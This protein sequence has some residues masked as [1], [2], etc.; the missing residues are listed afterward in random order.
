MSLPLRRLSGPSMV[1]PV[2]EEKGRQGTRE[3][4][5]NSTF[6]CLLPL[7]LRA[8]PPLWALA[9]PRRHHLP[10]CVAVVLPPARR[11][12]LARYPSFRLPAI[13]SPTP[14]PFRSRGWCCRLTFIRLA[15]VRPPPVHLVPAVHL[16]TARRCT[17]RGCPALPLCRL[18]ASVCRLPSPCLCVCGLRG[19]WSFV[20]LPLF[21]S[22]VSP[23]LSRRSPLCRVATGSPSAPHPAGCLATSRQALPQAGPHRRPS[24][25][26]VTRWRPL[27]V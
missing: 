18:A 20:R 25:I 3:S 17:H 5:A 14:R 10:S 16:S 27:G 8:A 1:K 6:P 22:C 7:R 15:P 2:G 23:S 21:V 19:W 26:D 11:A 24:S 13:V 12:A 4:E 9:S